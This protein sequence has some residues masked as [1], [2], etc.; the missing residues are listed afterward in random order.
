MTPAT[1]SRSGAAKAV[2]CEVAKGGSQVAAGAGRIQQ[3]QVAPELAGQ[4]RDLSGRFISGGSKGEASAPVQV[5]QQGA[6]VNMDAGL[7]DSAANILVSPE[8]N[9]VSE[10][11]SDGSSSGSSSAA[12]DC[13]IEGVG[14]PVEQQGMC[15]TLLE[16]V[17][18]QMA[19]HVF[20]ELPNP[21]PAAA[22]VNLGGVSS[23]KGEVN[24]LKTP[25]VN[26][27]KDNRNGGNGYKLE[28][29]EVEGD[30]VQLDEDDVGEV[31][32]A[33][34]ICLVGLFSGKFPGAGAIHRL[35]DAWKV[36]GKHWIL[37]LI[38]I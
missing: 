13:E 25:W 3:Q 35:W 30:L 10:Y 34:G 29:V 38:H 17:G 5:Q 16:N 2:D 36:K 14:R 37:S 18:A 33:V 19:H 20:D 23:E 28:E 27:F 31:E 12:S 22:E 24:G 7:Q 15:S 26:L 11:D 4:P 9:E 32:E 8:D 1:R 6:A 21:A